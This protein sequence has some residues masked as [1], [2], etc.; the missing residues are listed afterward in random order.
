MY[1]HSNLPDPIQRL[2]NLQNE[3]MPPWAVIGDVLTTLE[4]TSGADNDGEPWLRRVIKEVQKKGI[5]IG[6]TQIRKM[7]KTYK[8]VSDLMKLKRVDFEW[9]AIPE[10][11]FST[12]EVISRMYLLNQD[13]AINNINFIIENRITYAAIMKDYSAMRESNHNKFDQKRETIFKGE[14]W[15]RH[16]I[17]IVKSNPNTFLGSG[18]IIKEA[19]RE[20]RSR[21]RFGAAADVVFEVTYSSPNPKMEIIGFECIVFSSEIEFR[22]WPR[23]RIKIAFHSTF[24]QI[25][26][27]IAVMDQALAKIIRDEIADLSLQNIGLA[28]MREIDG[29]PEFDILLVPSGPPTPDRT[30]L[31]HETRS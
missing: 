23:Y 10:D 21:N 14:V 5:K 8:F 22:S 29:K 3:K 6:P 1:E 24:F 16:I 28:V 11:S 18:K 17:A 26:W 4:S 12:I 9:G 20:W 30:G 7:Q 25:Y 15:S 13:K 19:W 31:W 2:Q 27:I